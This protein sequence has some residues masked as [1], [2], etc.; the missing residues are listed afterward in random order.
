MSSNACEG[1]G[2]IRFV[3]SFQ[4]SSCLVICVSCR[5]FSFLS[6]VVVVSLFSVILYVLSFENLVKEESLIKNTWFS[7][8]A[9]FPSEAPESYV[10]RDSCGCRVVMS[11]AARSVISGLLAGF[12][13]VSIRRAAWGSLIGRA[14][15]LLRAR[16][17]SVFGHEMSKRR[18]QWERAFSKKSFVEFYRSSSFRS[19]TLLAFVTF[20]K[21]QHYGS[22]RQRCSPQRFSHPRHCES[23]S[24]FPSFSIRADRSRGLHRAP[25]VCFVTLTCKAHRN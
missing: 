19:S 20:Q 5:R 25:T 14:P 3:I 1:A 8:T 2:T 18:K 22:N 10:R 23:S 13:F 6:A 15:L 12:C 4:I 17:A 16:I 21:L 9:L 11:A 7:L 24:F